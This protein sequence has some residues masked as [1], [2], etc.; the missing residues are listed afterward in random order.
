VPDIP[1]PNPEIDQYP[2]SLAMLFIFMFSKDGFGENVLIFLN[3]NSISINEIREKCKKSEIFSILL[4][5]FWASQT[6]L[7]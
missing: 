7:L 6:L 1:M 3:P 5:T 2:N 4:S